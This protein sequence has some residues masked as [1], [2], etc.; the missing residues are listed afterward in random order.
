MVAL[1]LILVLAQG[2]PATSEGGQVTGVV[3][4]ENGV[5]ATGVRVAAASASDSLSVAGTTLIS[6][7]ETDN[8]G[9]FVLESV[10]A[11]RYYIIAGRIGQ[12]TFFPGTLEVAKGTL[13]T[14]KAGA[15][16]SD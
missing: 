15:R 1:F 7:S 2:V 14:I 5:P 9:R 6:L 3:R 8:E 4:A 11:G 12:P 10:P 13:L 16:V